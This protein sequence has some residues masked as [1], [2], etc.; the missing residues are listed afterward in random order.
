MKIFFF[1]NASVYETLKESYNDKYEYILPELTLNKNLFSND[2]FGSLDLQSNLKIHNY[3]T[4]K[5]T[6]FLVNDLNWTLKSS[7]LILE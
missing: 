6:N 2:N 7:I 1:L 4:N 5:T 3:D